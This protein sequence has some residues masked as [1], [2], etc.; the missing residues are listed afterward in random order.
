[1]KKSHEQFW[2]LFMIATSLIAA[3][4][5]AEF[6]KWTDDKPDIRKMLLL[7]EKDK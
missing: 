1:M 6:L 4:A 7:D 3:V 2:I 5:L